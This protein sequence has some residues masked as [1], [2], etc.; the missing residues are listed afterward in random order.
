MQKVLGYEQYAAECHRMAGK[1]KDPLYKQH[2]EKM[3]EVWERL[4]RERRQ[5][6]IENEPGSG[7]EQ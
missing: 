4:A 6:I 7:F 2:L 5:G 3:A 1:T